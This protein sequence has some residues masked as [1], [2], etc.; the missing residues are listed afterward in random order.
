MKHS[1]PEPSRVVVPASFV[2]VKVNDSDH[3]LMADIKKCSFPWS[4]SGLW[5]NI[6]FS[7][8]MKHNLTR[9]L[10]A[11]KENDDSYTRLTPLSILSIP[12]GVALFQTHENLE[13]LAV[14]LGPLPQQMIMRAE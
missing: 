7:C 10:L 5:S 2:N 8:L 1:E 3:S 11:N 12:E 6:N 4:C 14:V 9:S 13:I